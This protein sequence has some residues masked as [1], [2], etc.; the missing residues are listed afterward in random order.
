MYDI[1]I[2]GAGPAGLAASIYAA[3]AGL[4]AVVFD[5]NPM[6][7]GQILETYEIDNYP[8]LPGLSGMEL[9]QAMRKHADSFGTEFRT[10]IVSSIRDEGGV[11][12]LVTDKGTTEARTVIV[13]TGAKPRRLSIPGEDKFRGAGVSYCATC[14]GA[15]FRKKTVAVVGGGDTALE[16]ALY[17]ARGC[18]KVWLIH[19][20]D[21]FRGAAVLAEKVQN[22]E[23]IG[24][25]WNSTVESVNGTDH[26]TD[27]TVRNVKDG[28]EQQL[29]VQGL[30]VA[31]GTVPDTGSIEGLP[32]LDE[33]GYIRAG[34]DCVTSI[35]GIFA[36]GDIRTKQLRQVLTAAADGANAVV[37]AQR[38]L[39]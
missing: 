13:A 4:R 26:L 7:G 19:R 20:R 28:T 39:M 18:E 12:V 24:I 30:F 3:R 8:G 1:A 37:S 15:F 16:S 11:K 25:L 17:L 5:G 23:N 33:K 10:E 21:A 38:V 6:S 9:G 29:P 36:A 32:A 34:E 14:D 22:T 2:I 35:P 27:L 31:V